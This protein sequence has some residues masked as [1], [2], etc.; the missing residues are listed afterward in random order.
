MSMVNLSG[1]FEKVIGMGE[2]N[3]LFIFQDDELGELF[4]QISKDRVE[5]LNMIRINRRLNLLTRLFSTK[6]YRDDGVMFINNHLEVIDFAEI[7]LN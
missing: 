3:V 7:G 2:K 4:C 5:F 6:K 1:T